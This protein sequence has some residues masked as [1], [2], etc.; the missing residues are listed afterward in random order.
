MIFVDGMGN[1]FW[2]PMHVFNIIF[3]WCQTSI[4]NFHKRHSMTV[5]INH[6][7][8]EII[9]FWQILTLSSF[10]KYRSAIITVIIDGPYRNLFLWTKIN[11][12]KMGIVHQW[13][14]TQIFAE[15]T[16]D[17]ANTWH[18]QHS[19]QLKYYNFRKNKLPTLSNSFNKKTKN[20]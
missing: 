6:T 17:L 11:K 14:Q 18:L 20:H 15:K 10:M 12:I 7:K 9:N 16:D 1:K 2:I 5:M 3:Y 8:K 4:I 19:L 13:C